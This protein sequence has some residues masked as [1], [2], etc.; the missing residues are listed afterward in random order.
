MVPLVCAERVRVASALPVWVMVFVVAL[1]ERR[2]K[3][4]LKPLRSRVPVEERASWPVE[5]KVG[6]LPFLSVPALT[7]VVPL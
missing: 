7:V 5:V 2:V 4:A 1:A 6:A 3:E